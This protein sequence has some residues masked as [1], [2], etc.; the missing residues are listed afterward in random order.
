MRRWLRNTI[1]RSAELIKEREEKTSPSPVNVA[2][3]AKCVFC[4]TR[5]PLYEVSTDEVT[6]YICGE[7]IGSY[8]A[9]W[10][11][12]AELTVVRL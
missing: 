6:L 1:L 5:H 10:D 8:I 4:D 12:A 9:D 11:H 2:T 3:A 7:H